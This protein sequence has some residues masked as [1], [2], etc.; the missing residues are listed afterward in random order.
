M[1]YK[2]FTTAERL[3]Y[4]L[5]LLSNVSKGGT[6]CV[7]ERIFLNLHLKTDILDKYL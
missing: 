2:G 1:N 3:N 5:E 7:Q 4:C 6:Y